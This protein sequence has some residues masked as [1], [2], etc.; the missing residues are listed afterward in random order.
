MKKKE[1][2]RLLIFCIFFASQVYGT[3]Y[4]IDPQT[5]FMSNDGSHNAPWSRLDSVMQ[6]NHSLFQG[7]DTLFLRSGYH[8]DRVWIGSAP[9]V[10]IVIIAEEGQKPTLLNLIVDGS[11]WIIDGLTFTQEGNNGKGTPGTF[12][13]GTFVSLGIH[14][15][16]VVLKNCELYSIEDASG[17][18]LTDWRNNVWSGIKDYGHHNTFIKNHLF[19][20]AFA[21]QL[22][23]ECDSALVAYNTIENFSGD[24][25]RVGGADFCILKSNVI[26]GSVELDSN[27]TVGNHEDGIQAW[28]GTQN[29][30]AVNGLQVIGNLIIN[31]SSLTQPFKGIMQGIGFFDGPY[32]DCVIENNV[33]IVEHWHGISLFGAFNCKIINN[34]VLPYPG[35]KPYSAGPPWIGVFKHKDGTESKNNIVRNNLATSI[36]IESGS[37]IADH[38]V[39]DAEAYNFV[40]D[41]NNFDYH[42]KPGYSKGSLSIIDA[43]S[44]D[45]APQ[46]DFDGVHRPQGSAYDIGAFEFVDSTTGINDA[47]KGAIGS[48]FSLAQNYPN[49]FN[50][51]TVIKYSI[52]KTVEVRL[53]VYDLLGQKIK[54]LINKNQN[55]GRYSV[56]W[57]GKDTY[58]NNVASG[59]YFYQLKA[60]RFLKTLKMLLIK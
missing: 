44:S 38:N 12:D 40:K 59:M 58:N 26:R 2:L 51:T 15:F 4:Y 1:I 41:Y 23:E 14:S 53:S 3:N 39:I 9:S 16:N 27:S 45:G 49:P 37:S 36:N 7:G 60:G 52:S 31:Y 25:I 18:G 32:Q 34:S 17:W 35:T 56:S 6:L 22:M 55:A 46:L 30:D 8:G 50:P 33:V 24:G 29:D 21:V 10:P 43:G 42:P 20:I 11:N 19:N 13:N 5:G 47:P 28:K 48:S 57:N 54:T